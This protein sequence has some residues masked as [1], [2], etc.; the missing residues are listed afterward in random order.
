MTAITEI[1]VAAAQT[2]A[3]DGFFDVFQGE[4]F[5]GRIVADFNSEF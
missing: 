2:I 3:L 1:S 4:F 5:H